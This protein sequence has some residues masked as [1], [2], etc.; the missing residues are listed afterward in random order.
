MKL[1]FSLRFQRSASDEGLET[2]AGHVN[3][4]NFRACT[5]DFTPNYRNAYLSY[6][7][8]TQFAPDEANQRPLTCILYGEKAHTHRALL[9][10]SGYLPCRGRS[11]RLSTNRAPRSSS[12]LV[13]RHESIKPDRWCR[14]HGQSGRRG[15]RPIFPFILHPGGTGSRRYPP[16]HVVSS[17]GCFH[18]WHESRPL[19]LL[20]LQR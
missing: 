3:A 18:R 1:R 11:T 17:S 9:D 14:Y 5:F 15:T 13:H 12:Q 20:R 19:R 10:K 6:D 8:I 7:T 16:T 2:L 4:K